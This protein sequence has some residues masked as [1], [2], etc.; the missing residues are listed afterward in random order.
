MENKK[1]YIITEGSY[2]DYRILTVC[3]TKQ[4]AEKVILLF[5]DAGIEEWEIDTFLS[6]G[7]AAW[8][9]LLTGDGD[10]ERVEKMDDPSMVIEGSF[11]VLLAHGISAGSYNCFVWGKDE[12]HAVKVASEK[13]RELKAGVTT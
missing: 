1:V 8:N 11:C 2:S 6:D 10:V 9:V 5:D 3:S 13:C 7:R 12:Q 4:E